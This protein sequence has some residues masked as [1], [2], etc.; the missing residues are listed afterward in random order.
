MPG[1]FAMQIG[2]LWYATPDVRLLFVHRAR[3]IAHDHVLANR[4]SSLFVL[5]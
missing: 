3:S 5:L 4:G 2:P 1:I